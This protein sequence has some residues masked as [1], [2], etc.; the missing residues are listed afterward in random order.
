MNNSNFLNLF[1]NPNV[2]ADDSNKNSNQKSET[3]NN[4]CNK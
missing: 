1:K 4:N 2:K 3:K